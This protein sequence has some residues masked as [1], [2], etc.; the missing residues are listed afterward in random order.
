M[1]LGEQLDGRESLDLVVLVL[2]GGVHLGDD[3]VLS[4]IE[5]LTGLVQGRGELLAVTTP[6]DNPLLR[7]HLLSAVKTWVDNTLIG[8]KGCE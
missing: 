1:T 5:L 3:N 7:N 2:V 4:V 6:R 8:T